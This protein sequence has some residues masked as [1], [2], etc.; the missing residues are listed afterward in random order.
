MYILKRNNLYGSEIIGIFTTFQKAN[1]Y[2]L[3][4]STFKKEFSIE[5]IDTDPEPD[6]NNNN[7]FPFQ[8]IIN[9]YG[10]IVNVSG[11]SHR[12]CFKKPFGRFKIGSR[13]YGPNWFVNLFAENKEQ[14]S[15]KALEIREDLILV[16]KWPS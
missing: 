3:S 8:V 4:I 6:K 5:P 2:I 15:V 10:K 14:A 11:I 9:K 1:E 7:I 16:E 13:S 12:F